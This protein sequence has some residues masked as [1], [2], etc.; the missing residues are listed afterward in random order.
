MISLKIMNIS[1]LKL[2]LS[3]AHTLRAA[4]ASMQEYSYLQIWRFL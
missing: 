4:S 2:E 1:A 3:R